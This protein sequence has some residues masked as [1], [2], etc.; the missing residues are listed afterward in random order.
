M[1]D[2]QG[3]EDQGT[4]VAGRPAVATTSTANRM[5]GSKRAMSSFKN[6]VDKDDNVAREGAAWGE[7]RRHDTPRDFGRLLAAT[8]LAF[9]R[10]IVRI[11]WQLLGYLFEAIMVVLTIIPAVIDVSICLVSFVMRSF[12]FRKLSGEPPGGS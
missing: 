5:S 1:V 11:I 6:W 10:V 4:V 7:N 12:V 9:V 3:E 2:P 8:L